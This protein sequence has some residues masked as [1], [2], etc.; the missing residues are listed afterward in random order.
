VL[1]QRRINPH[2]CPVASI[3]G[4]NL[5]CGIM[6]QQVMRWVESATKEG[7]A[8]ITNRRMV[9]TMLGTA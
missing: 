3:F 6:R 8:D 1:R 9:R 5:A 4:R 7:R 2:E